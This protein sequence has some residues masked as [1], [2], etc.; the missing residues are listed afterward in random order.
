MRFVLASASPRRREILTRLG[1]SFT[2]H[3]S[4]VPEDDAEGSISDVVKNLAQRKAES[5]AASEK[6]ALIIAADTL[7][8]LDGE[9][10][11]KPA[12]KEDA[13]RM[14]KLLSGR[15]HEVTTGIC[16]I[17]TSN[18]KRAVSSDTTFVE[19]KSLSDEEIIRYVSTGEPMDKAGGYAIQGGAGAFVKRYTG[20]YDNIVGF[21]SELFVRMLN[22]MI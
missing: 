3:C 8:G 9:K 6:D 1:Y 21:P 18:G 16:L 4:N 5:A 20:S 15:T 11:G 12:D 17:D 10:L 7:V 14:L 13:F 22:E 2:V 19:F